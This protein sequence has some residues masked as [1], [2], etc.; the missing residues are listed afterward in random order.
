KIT[1]LDF[2]SASA[3]KVINNWVSDRT[4][5]KIPTIIDQISP[6]ML[7]FLINAIYFKGSWQEKFDVSET[8][9]MPFTKNDGT[10]LNTD[11]MT[12]TKEF[13]II[14]TEQ[15]QGIE[16]PYGNGQYSMFALLPSNQSVNEF[17]NGLNDMAALGDIYSQ[18]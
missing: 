17:V 7:M 8:S 16:L 4:N 3:P 11:F 10:V 6:D 12:I 2:A 15:L 14:N 1:A 5:G 9:Q 13:N 18:F